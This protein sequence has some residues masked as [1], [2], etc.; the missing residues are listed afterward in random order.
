[1]G[2]TDVQIARLFQRRI[3]LDALFGGL[4]GFV[5]ALL[6]IILL[7]TRLTATGSDLLAAISLPWS[8]WLILTALP[9]G[10]VLL[11]TLAARWTVLRSLGRLL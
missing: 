3:G 10:G 11:A 7:G 1:M 6:V 2:A 8:S 4:L 9:V 5:T